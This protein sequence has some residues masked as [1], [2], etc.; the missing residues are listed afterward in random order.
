MTDKGEGDLNF[1]QLQRITHIDIDEVMK[2]FINLHPLRLFIAKDLFIL[3]CQIL[4]RNLYIFNSQ[5]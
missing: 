1:H 5:L 4:A 3:D 2:M